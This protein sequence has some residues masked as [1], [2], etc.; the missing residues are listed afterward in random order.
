VDITN[1]A[2]RPG[3]HVS[4]MCAGLIR[5]FRFHAVCRAKSAS[6]G[7]Y[8]GYIRSC[9]THIKVGPP[10]TKKFFGVHRCGEL[11][12]EHLSTCY[13]ERP[14]N[15]PYQT[16]LIR[17]IRPGASYPVY[18]IYVMTSETVGLYI[19]A[20]ASNVSRLLHVESMIRDDNG[21]TQLIR[22]RS[23]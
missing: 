16:G 3:I 19:S 11:S 14:L 21:P 23:V 22:H 7:P 9:V 20:S 13:A 15:E 5:I 1:N 10:T 17:R 12:S 18:R 2:F 6:I 8:L 4:I